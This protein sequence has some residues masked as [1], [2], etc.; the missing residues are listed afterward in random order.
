MSEENVKFLDYEE[1]VK[2]VGAIQEEED[3]EQPDKR[4]LTVYGKDDKELC[5][6]DFDEVKAEVGEVEAGERKAAVQHY[7]LT[8]IPEWVYEL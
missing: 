5:W 7:I 6:F 4:I 3:I 2:L 1:A 8:H